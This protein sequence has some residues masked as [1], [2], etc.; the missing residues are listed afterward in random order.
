M[1]DI[2]SF[3]ANY[4]AASSGYSLGKLKDNPGDDTGSALTSALFNDLLYAF[5]AFILKYGT[6][7]D[8]DESESA[9]D[10]V[11]ALEAAIAD[12]AVLLTGAQTVAGVKTFSDGIVSDVTGNA[13]TATQ[14]DSATQADG[15]KETGSSAYVVHEKIIAIGD[16]NMDAD[17][18]KDI[19]HGLDRTKI[20]S[21]RA[22]VWHDSGESYFPIDFMP[23]SGS[24]S[25]NIHVE[26]NNI[27][28]LRFAGGYFDNTEFNSTSYNRGWITIEY[29]D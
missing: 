13:D 9:S 10:F 20:I 23:N 19:A 8:T 1:K 14:A 18:G 17:L 4:T 26:Q 25:G 2:R 15:I 6:V 3:L 7:S 22:F 28:L 11:D 21:C 12:L 27:Q 29:V 24:V 5:Y 16:W